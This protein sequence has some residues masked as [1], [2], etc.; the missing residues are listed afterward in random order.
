MGRWSLVVGHALLTPPQ[1]VL[2]NEAGG[3]TN[4]CAPNLLKCWPFT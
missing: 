3:T 2:T 1:Q 4:D